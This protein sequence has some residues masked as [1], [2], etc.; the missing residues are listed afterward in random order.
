[1]FSSQCVENWGR[2]IREQILGQKSQEKNWWLKS[3]KRGYE[4]L[5]CVAE[6]C[7]C[8]RWLYL[9]A[10]TGNSSQKTDGF[11]FL[12]QKAWIFFYI[13]V[14]AGLWDRR[15]GSIFVWKWMIK[16]WYMRKELHLCD[17]GKKEK[18]QW[19]LNSNIISVWQPLWQAVKNELIW[20]P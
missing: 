14:M 5:V 18:T 2:R 1:M 16:E 13:Q 11:N 19:Q 7:S 6:K 10:T 3:P 15:W 17:R 20:L 4:L 9:L 12:N 8:Y